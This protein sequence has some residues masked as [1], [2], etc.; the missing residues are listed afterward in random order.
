MALLLKGG[1]VVDPQVGLEEIADILIED[2]FIKR[3]QKTGNTSTNPCSLIPNPS[4]GDGFEVIDCSGKV[5]VPGLVDAHVHL[6][7]PGFEHKEDIESG[8]RAA[9]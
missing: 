9:V 7:E 2:G 1:L 4:E 5:V 8:T 6:R 3:V